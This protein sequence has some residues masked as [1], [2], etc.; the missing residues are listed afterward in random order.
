VISVKCLD[1]EF[2]EALEILKNLSISKESSEN[3][4]DFIGFNT[5]KPGFAGLVNNPN[6][7]I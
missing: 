7:D 6:R 5:D 1:I 3:D 4:R 2:E